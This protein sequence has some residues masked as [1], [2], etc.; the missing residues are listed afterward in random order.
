MNADF[1]NAETGKGMSAY[2]S[3]ASRRLLAFCRAAAGT[4]AAAAA[5]STHA[6]LVTFNFNDVVLSG[7]YGNGLGAVAGNAPIAT[8]MNSALSAAGFGAASVSVSGGL[9]TKTYNGEGHVIGQSLGISDNGVNHAGNDTFIM[10]NNFGIGASSTDRFTLTFTNFKIYSL[11]FDWQI[12]PDATCPAGSW[13]ASHPSDSNWP[14]IALL[15]GASNTPVWSALA[16]L[17]NSGADPQAI[18]HSPEIYLNGAQSLTFRDWPA[19]IGIDNLRIEGCLASAPN[20]LNTSVPEPSSLPLAALAL[21][22]G[23]FTYRSRRKTKK[24]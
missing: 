5:F 21:T 12:F 3:G 16:T 15:I 18:G 20:C 22:L 17:P 6:G 11:S 7:S 8:S 13:C 2:A 1:V 24:A 9:A 23:V 4:V 10:N 19:E 14:D